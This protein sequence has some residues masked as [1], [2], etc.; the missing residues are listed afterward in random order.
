MAVIGLV[1]EE[2]KPK[3]EPVKT[4]PVEEKKE[5]TTKK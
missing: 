5:K 2:K 4:E 3:K 1:F